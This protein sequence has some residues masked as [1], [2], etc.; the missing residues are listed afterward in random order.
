[1]CS[2]VLST[3]LGLT[4]A[5]QLAT[6]AMPATHRTSQPTSQPSLELRRSVEAEKLR[7][8][9]LS[10][11][12]M[13]P[14]ALVAT[15]T[16]QLAEPAGLILADSPIAASDGVHRLELTDLPGLAQINVGQAGQENA[17]WVDFQ[18]VEF[19]TPD[20]IVTLLQVF[21]REDYLMIAYDFT[22]AREEC[23]VQVIQ[24]PQMAENKDEIFR[25]YVERFDSVTD[26]SLEKITLKADSL[27][28]MLA[29]HRDES[30]RY[31]IA[32][33]R[34]RKLHRGVLRVPSEVAWQVLGAS[35]PP[36]KEAEDRVATLVR[37]L[38]AEEYAERETAATEL[39]R[40]GAIT[41]LILRQID[42]SGLSEEQRQA[43]D[44]IISSYDRL[45][46]EHI[47]QRKA[48]P[49]FHLGILYGDETSL[50]PAAAAALGLSLSKG[51]E[52]D[53]EQIRDKADAT[54]TSL[55]QTAKP[56]A[57]S[58]PVTTNGQ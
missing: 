30:M 20:A 24:A 7:T 54:L 26:D 13:P 11:P 39:R 51:E 52:S 47:E 4:G 43:V 45:S 38:D 15:I 6:N 17:R 8:S 35:V 55:L 5:S 31:I 9:M 16:L 25:L 42:R 58:Q 49:L 2:I 28:T 40:G 10:L 37:K 1:M 41:A 19:A 56:P 32:P 57:A 29:T 33:L 34:D 12:V 27:R 36:P 18:H 48:D 21:V 22:G 53:V 44:T 3:L 14:R 46:Q 50:W 23:R